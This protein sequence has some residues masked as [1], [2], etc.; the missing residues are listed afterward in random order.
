MCYRILD[1]AGVYR[2]VRPLRRMWNAWAARGFAKHVLARR[3]DAVVVTHFLPADVC[4]SLKQ[5]G[6]L[7]APV[8]VVVTDLHPHR[9]W[10]TPRAEA[11]VAAVPQSADA[12]RACG[13]DPS[14]IHVLGIPV[15]PA[16]ADRPD[17]ATLR[18]DL[19]LESGRLTALVT[20]GGTTV[21][22]FE[23]TVESLM[24]LEAEFP[25]RLQLIVVCGQDAWARRRLEARAAGARM[26]V[27]VHGFI[28]T[29][30][31]VMAASDL[32]V[33]KAGGLTVSEALASG[34]PLVV[35]H[36]VPGQEELNARYVVEHGAGVIAQRPGE[37]A[38]VI[39]GCL[40]DPARL[41]RMRD[42]AQALSRPHAA[43][44]I[45]E[46]VVI[47][48]VRCQAKNDA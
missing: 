11:M 44:D 19:G 43:R 22:R 38:A 45:I 1:T 37:A 16:F 48:L 8:V 20:S 34:K 4:N 18:R 6:R 15:G 5:A 9:F 27:R 12:L 36:I 7:S 29:M 3:P 32:V 40:T 31:Q 25:G 13:V 47:P 46:R 10:L 17:P 39:A 2:L 41:E 30:A 24:A 14:R 33:S 42:G 35:Y 21:G 23:E 28:E 26:P